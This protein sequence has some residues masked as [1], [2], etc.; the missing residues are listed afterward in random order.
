MLGAGDDVEGGRLS[1]FELQA[2]EVDAAGRI[3][4]QAIYNDEFDFADFL[5]GGGPA[6]RL[7]ARFDAVLDRGFVLSVLPLLAFVDEGRVGYGVRLF[8]GSEMILAR[9][10]GSGGD[11]VILVSS[12]DPS[13]DGGAY[14]AF[15]AGI[16]MPG[17]LASDGG[18]AI[19]LAAAT[20]AGPEAIVFFGRANTA[21]TADAGSDL[22]AECAGPEGT[23][24]TLDGGASSDP[25][26]D[27][28]Q[29]RWTGPFGEAAG[30]RPGVTLPL[31]VSIVTLVVEDGRMASAP[32]HVR[33]E[34]R[35]T[36]APSIAAVATPSLLW[37]PDGRFVEVTLGIQ[38]TDRCDPA[39][40]VVL[41]DVALGDR[42]AGRPGAAF[43]GASVGMDD[44]LVSLRADRSGSGTG[45]SYTLIY[46]AT[47]G[48]GNTSRATASVLVPHD[49]GQ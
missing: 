43:T 17:R 19:A 20:T 1:P 21:P 11:P 40:R 37:P 38:V 18:G 41:R 39:P 47:D 22:T 24:V 7:V 49:R 5:A 9:E 16:R 10:P 25:D 14:L 30:P 31:G 45:R 32:D 35:D 15:G 48:S 23:V 29:Y 36:L 2:L 44:R 46:D 4:F 26:G 8:D 42:G 3:A 28:L 12:G 27:A 6:S 34:V 13:P 33:V